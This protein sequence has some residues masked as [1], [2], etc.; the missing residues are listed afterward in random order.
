MELYEY[1]SE[2]ARADSSRTD[3]LGSTTTTTA[4]LTRPRQERGGKEGRKEKCVVRTYTAEDTLQT[5][6]NSVYSLAISSL[7]LAV[8]VQL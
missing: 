8:S 4:A 2:R 6:L 7:T 3:G 1:V 5:A